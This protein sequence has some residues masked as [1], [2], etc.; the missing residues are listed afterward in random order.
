MPCLL[1]PLA[2]LPP[3]SLTVCQER[4]ILIHPKAYFNLWMHLDEVDLNIEVL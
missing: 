3:F 2:E 4:E 1:H